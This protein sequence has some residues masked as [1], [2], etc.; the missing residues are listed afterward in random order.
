M[1]AKTLMHTALHIGC[2]A[3]LVLQGHR[4]VQVQKD[5]WEDHEYMRE[6]VVHEANSAAQTRMQQDDCIQALNNCPAQKRW[7]G[8]AMK[9]NC[10]KP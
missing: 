2:V 4:I 9:N 7:S 3:L 5:W 1:N 8:S 10:P 6:L